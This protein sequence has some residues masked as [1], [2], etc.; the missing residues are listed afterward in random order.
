MIEEIE[1]E[2]TTTG[3]DDNNKLKQQQRQ[4]KYDLPPLPYSSFEI[5][6]NL[7]SLLADLDRMLM[8]ENWEEE[9]LSCIDKDLSDLR[10]KTQ[11]KNRRKSRSKD[12]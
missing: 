11:H 3:Q 6:S 1:K 10:Q 12:Y 4:V 5:E 7:I 8:A 9:T 2:A